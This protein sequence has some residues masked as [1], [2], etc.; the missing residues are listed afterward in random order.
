[1]QCKHKSI[2]LNYPTETAKI[3][4]HDIFWFFL[5]DG[6]F[7]SKTINGGT[8]DLERFPASKVRQLAKRMESFRATSCHIKQVV[9][10]PQAMQ[11]NL[12]RHQHTEISS[13]KCKI[14]K[15]FVKSRQP[16][17]KNPGNENPQVSS[18]HKK[19]F[20][21]KNVYKKRRDAQSVEISPVWKD[22]GAL[23]EIPM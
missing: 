7:V 23:E 1:M 21:P 9:H 20:D 5:H 13:G 6:E 12:I 16:S 2:L 11:I 4:P 8:V 17:H 3:L 10:D 18:H 14:K 22:F 15:S 19:I